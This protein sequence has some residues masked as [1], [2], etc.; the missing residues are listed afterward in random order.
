[1]NG[2]DGH[3]DGFTIWMARA[4]DAYERAA[5]TAPRSQS[6]SYNVS[7][8]MLQLNELDRSIKF[9]ERAIEIDPLR[10]GPY[11][12]AASIQARLG[13]REAAR[14]VHKRALKWGRIP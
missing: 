8:I 2:D 1:M 6:M 12:L 3:F 9:A 10:R 14:G 11:E 5:T 7:I 4:D 13:R